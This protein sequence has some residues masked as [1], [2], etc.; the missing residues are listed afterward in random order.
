[1]CCYFLLFPL[2]YKYMVMSFDV[3]NYTGSTQLCPY[4]SATLTFSD[5][6]VLTCPPPE[7]ICSRNTSISLL[8][9]TSDVPLSCKGN[10]HEICDFYKYSYSTKGVMILVPLVQD[11]SVQHIV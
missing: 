4:D 1:M 9:S 5:G 3:Y 7:L 10:D 8:D 6:A 2:Y 11:L